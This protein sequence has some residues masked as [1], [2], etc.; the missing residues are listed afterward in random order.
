MPVLKLLKDLVLVKFGASSILESLSR[1]H[2]FYKSFMPFE[3]PFEEH[4]SATYN[5]AGS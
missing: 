3:A 2:P 1:D 5:P 4:K